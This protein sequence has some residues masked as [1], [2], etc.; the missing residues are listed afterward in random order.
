M[1]NGF[2]ENFRMPSLVD[3]HK[4]PDLSCN[5]PNTTDAI[6]GRPI[7]LVNFCFAMSNLLS[8][9]PSVPSQRLP[10]P[11]SCNDMTRLELI[12][13]FPVEYFIHSAVPAFLQIIPFS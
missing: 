2:S 5:T 1:L 13:E 10:A 9:P 3:N 4:P 8:P 6:P 12:P 7:K 11:S